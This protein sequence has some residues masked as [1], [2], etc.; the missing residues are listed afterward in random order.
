LDKGKVLGIL[1][2]LLSLSLAVV[3]ILAAFSAHGWDPM[4]TVMSGSTPLENMTNLNISENMFSVSEPTQGP[5][6]TLVI[7]AQFTSP[8][9][10]SMKI[11]NI[12]GEGFSDGTRIGSIQ[13]ASEVE[14]L[15]N[16]TRNLSII[17]TPT[18]EGRNYIENY[19]LQHHGSLPQIQPK[20]A[21][22]SIDIYGIIIE[23]T[24]G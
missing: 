21:R 9:N 3:P 16:T 14:F 18:P 8:F 1:L 10:F 13:L 22:L 15:P 11:E 19:A 5:N 2:S 24:F 20:N 23:G 6:N 17:C 7:N 4:A 12:S